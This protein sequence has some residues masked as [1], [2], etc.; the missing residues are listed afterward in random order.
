MCDL[1]V[2]LQ[3]HADMFDQNLLRL[4]K[5]YFIAYGSKSSQYNELIAFFET[6]F[7]F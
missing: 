6:V 3:D 1:G 7:R 2:A 4:L 5:Q